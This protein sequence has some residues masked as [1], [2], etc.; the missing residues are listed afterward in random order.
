MSTFGGS[1]IDVGDLAGE[2]DLEP[3]QQP[4]MDSLI[5]QHGGQLQDALDGI[6]G[7]S[8]FGP[9]TL[10]GSLNASDLQGIDPRKAEVLMSVLENNKGMMQEMLVSSYGVDDLVEDVGGPLG[11]LVSAIKSVIDWVF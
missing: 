7:N 5:Q 6:V 3:W 11:G 1:G 9:D 8:L 4:M 2:W 10:S